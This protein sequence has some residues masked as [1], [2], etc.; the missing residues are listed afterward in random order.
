M[1]AISDNRPGTADVRP[2]PTGERFRLP[3]PA[4]YVRP[5][6]V[7]PAPLRLVERLVGPEQQVLRR[8]PGG[9]HGGGDPQADRDEPDRRADVLLL[10]GGHRE[11][12]PLGDPAYGGQTGTGQD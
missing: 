11:P 12:G 3:G 1:T 6:P 7:A 2:S 5:D 10:Q 4:R 9:R 8:G